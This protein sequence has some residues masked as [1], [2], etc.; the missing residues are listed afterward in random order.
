MSVSVSVCT[1]TGMCE[2]L[3]KEE[4]KQFHALLI[5]LFLMFQKKTDIKLSVSS[6]SPL[7]ICKTNIG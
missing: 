2:S 4:K 5:S 6:C 3:I 7:A 1:P